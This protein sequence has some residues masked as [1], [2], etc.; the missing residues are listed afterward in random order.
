VAEDSFDTLQMHDCV[1]R[2]QAGDK[3][4]ADILLRRVGQRLEHMTRRMLHGF[5]AVHACTE[6]ADVFQA[7][8]I[9]LLNTLQQVQ[10]E[11][12]RHFFN[13]A[14][15]QVRRE[16]LDLARHFNRPE[17]ARPLPSKDGDESENAGPV[18]AA[19]AAPEDRDL[20]L[21]CRFHEAV[22]Q[23]PAE[24]R[25]V[26]GLVYYHGWTQK[27]IAELFQVDERTIRRRWQSACLQIH[28]LVGDLPVA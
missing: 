1:G 12:T 23:L 21:W 3:A 8:L 11:S 16:L 5:P 25:E 9:R 4:A 18:E 24:E 26:L 7:S 19:A 27:Q 15:V 10:P 14:A 2:W 17:F 28:Q 6:T 13:L 22:E 20:D